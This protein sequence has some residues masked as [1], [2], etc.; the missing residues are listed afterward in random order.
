MLYLA[1]AA[2]AEGRTKGLPAKARPERELHHLSYCVFRLDVR[3]ANA[4]SLVRQRTKAKNDHAAGAPDGLPICE[5]IGESEFDLRA[6]AQRS[7]GAS[8]CVSGR[9]AS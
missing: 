3:N 4:R 7:A 9:Q 8:R 6:F 1:A 5:K 2:R